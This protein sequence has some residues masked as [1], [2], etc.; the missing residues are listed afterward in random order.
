MSNNNTKLLFLEQAEKWVCN[1]YCLGVSYLATKREGT[2]AILDSLVVASPNP[3]EKIVNFS[4][5]VGTL[6]AG[7]HIFP[8][9]SKI[10][11]LNWLLKA[12][13]GIIHVNDL[14]LNLDLG[15][16]P[17]YY[18]ATP[19]SDVWYSEL[20][21]QVSGLKLSPA[22]LEER[23]ANDHALR[24]AH[25]PFDGL[26]DLGAFLR[27]VDTRV[28]SQAPRI[29]IR[30]V[31][32]LAMDFLASNLRANKFKFVVNA[33]PKF[34][35]DLFGLAIRELPGSGTE[36]R[37]QVSQHVKWKLLPNKSRQGTLEQSLSNS[38]SVLV[39]LT[40]SNTT[41]TRQWFIDPDKAV[42]SRYIAAQ[43]F[44]KDLKQ[45]RI[46]VLEST[47]SSK[48]ELGIASLLFLL[49]FSPA[50]QVETQAPD[51]VVSTIGGKVAV[52]ECTMRVSDFQTKMGKLV[53]RR[54]ALKT[55]LEVAGHHLRVDAF[56]IS[57]QP[58]RQIAIQD[59]YLAQHRVTLLCKEDL[60]RAFD[61]VRNATDPDS[62]LDRANSQFPTLG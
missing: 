26:A 22:P 24:R 17:D 13:E 7:Q 60:S 51:I 39:M 47:D 46:A 31:P 34:N 52:V 50:I 10:K 27:L 56:L 14:K 55:A 38:D 37:K 9:L 30:V 43:L 3:P 5:Q 6:I 29:G 42:N 2:L 16:A 59:E 15:E 49:G 41:F 44:D 20:D 62:M 40:I 18:S 33:H 23:I 1:S 57:A 48:F 35:T 28:N 21:L 54:N 53:D 19:H 8:S 11:I 45:L 32:P 61:Q 25:P 4:T 12:S 36:T 58:R